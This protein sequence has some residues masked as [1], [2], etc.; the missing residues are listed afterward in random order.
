VNGKVHIKASIATAWD[1]ASRFRREPRLS[2]LYYHGVTPAQAGAFDAQMAYLRANANIVRADHQGPLD[3]QRPNVAVTFDDA[4]RSVRDNAV[5][6]LARHG[7]HATIYVPSGWLGKTP[8]WAMETSGDADEVVMSGAELLA[9][10]RDV[11]SSG[12]H[13]VRHRHLTRL[14]DDDIAREFIDSRAALEDLFGETID[15]LAIPYGHYD[16]R[17]AGLA[18]GAG[19]RHIFSVAPQAIA[20]GDRGV[21]RGRTSVEPTDPIGLF[22]LKARGAYAWMPLATRLKR[23]LSLRS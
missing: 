3:P 18:A 20:A 15:T 21:L 12:S 10:P 11:V 14:A 8:G 4:F 23:A 16:D 22:A 7:V 13:T 6:S 5:P 2:I 1:L 9:L 19:Y 17:T